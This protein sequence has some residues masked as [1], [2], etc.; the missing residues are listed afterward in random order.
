MEVGSDPREQ[1]VE[2]DNRTQHVS[3]TETEDGDETERERQT[4]KETNRNPAET[5]E[6]EGEGKQQREDVITRLC[7]RDPIPTT[8][9]NSNGRW[10]RSSPPSLSG[11]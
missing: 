8:K 3:T 2:G 7:L 11:L 4:E 9:E 5:E 1:E 6:E 10:V